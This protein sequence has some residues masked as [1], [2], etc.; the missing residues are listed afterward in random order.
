[1][2][3]PRVLAAALAGVAALGTA[4]A[5]TPK[6]PTPQ[7][8]P[9]RTSTPPAAVPQPE[10]APAAV[11][12]QPTT[13]FSFM[14]I[15]DVPYRVP[16]DFV[17][18]DRLIAAVNATNPAF[19]FHVGDIKAANEPCTDEYFRGIFNRFK[20]ITGPL[21]YTPGDNEWTDCH[22]ERAGKFN[23][24]ERLDKVR[25]IFFAEPGRSLGATPM[26]I[27]SQSVVMPN[28]A[29][30]VENGRFWRNGVLFVTVHV[31]GGNNGLEATELEAASEYFDRNKANVVWLDDS[32]KLARDQ[33]A[34]AVVRR[35]PRQP[36]RYPPAEPRDATGVRARRYRART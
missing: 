34:K 21:I 28:H 12:T 22:R 25:E 13:P 27:D 18:F 1:M 19:T 2:I 9:S 17:R 11:P 8:P 10:A 14:V 3:R 23:P 24:R 5:Q 31:V 4:W 20:K 35:A 36:L 16:Q 29:R 32:F 15:G 26:P 6:S 30:Y 33:G 7:S